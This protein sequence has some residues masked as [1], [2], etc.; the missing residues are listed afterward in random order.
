MA[1]FLAVVWVFAPFLEM[2]SAVVVTAYMVVGFSALNGKLLGHYHLSSFLSTGARVYDKFLTIYTSFDQWHHSFE[3][4]PVL[5]LITTL[6][7]LNTLAFKIIIL[8]WP[9]SSA[10]LMQY[11]HTQLRSPVFTRLGLNIQLWVSLNFE[12]NTTIS[13]PLNY[14]PA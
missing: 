9:L 1:S 10:G 2:T 5:W 13:T 11:G 3:I 7:P 8:P 12:F 6:S 14:R 4:G